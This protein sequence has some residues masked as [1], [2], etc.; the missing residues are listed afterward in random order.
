VFARPGVL[1]AG[2]VLL[3]TLTPALV[4][5]PRA[6]QWPPPETREGWSP[7]R[8]HFVRVIPGKG[9]GETVGFRGAPTGPHATAELYR[10]ASDRSYRLA[11]TISLVNPVAPIDLFLTD[12][13]YLV[14]LDNWHNMGYGKIFAF[15]SP[16]GSLI[17]SYAL[18]DLFSPAGSKSSRGRCLR[19]GGGSSSRTFGRTSRAS[20]CRWVMEAGSSS[21]RPRPAPTSF[22]RR[23]TESTAVAARMTSDSGE[24]TAT[25]RS[26]LSVAAHRGYLHS[27]HVGESLIGGPW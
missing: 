17:R 11:W 14:T 1:T 4:T 16:E 8:D 27:D 22:V 20:T 15:Y 6:D 21:S 5:A 19:S 13:G 9:I 24:D 25:L 7:S 23:E 18:D 12:R 10:R 3:A 2:A 26:A